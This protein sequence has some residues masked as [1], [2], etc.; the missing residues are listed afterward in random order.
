MKRLL[1]VTDNAMTARTYL[2]IKQRPEGNKG[3]REYA[4]CH[5]RVQASYKERTP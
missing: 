3:C 5:C 1:T 2:D 4:N